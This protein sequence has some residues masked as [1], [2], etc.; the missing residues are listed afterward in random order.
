[1]FCI[2]PVQR[3]WA[4]FTWK[5]ALEIRSLLLLLLKSL[6][7]L[8]LRTAGSNPGSWEGHLT[9]RPLRQFTHDN[10]HTLLANLLDHR[11]YVRLQTALYLCDEKD[12]I[13]CRGATPPVTVTWVVPAI[14]SR[15]VPG[16]YQ[17]LQLQQ[18][19]TDS[20]V[21]VRISGTATHHTKLFHSAVCDVAK[22]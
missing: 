11:V 14:S 1:M 15:S 10:E 18:F 8:D 17:H 16:I 19:E 4:C 6:G 22:V 2:A 5:G 13:S 7:W 21:V 12:N 3:N 20:R 9:L